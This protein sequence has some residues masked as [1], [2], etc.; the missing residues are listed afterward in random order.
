MIAIL[1]LPGNDHYEPLWWFLEIK[2][3][4]NHPVQIICSDKPTIAWGV[5]YFEKHPY[6]HGVCKPSM[7]LVMAFDEGSYCI[8]TINQSINHGR[9]S[10]NT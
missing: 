7:L 8:Y 9:P 5:P 1:E 3:P 10:T 4:P 6:H 2:A